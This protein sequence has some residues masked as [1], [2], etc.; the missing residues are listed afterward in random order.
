MRSGPSQEDFLERKGLASGRMLK[1]GKWEA[2]GPERASS[3]LPQHP[4]M[5]PWGF[6]G[7]RAKEDFIYSTSPAV[8]QKVYRKMLHRGLGQPQAPSG[9]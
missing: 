3:I 1:R 7:L 8:F 2:A 4:L 5:I 9:L 6:P